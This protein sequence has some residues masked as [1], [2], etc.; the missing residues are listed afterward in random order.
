MK[1]KKQNFQK[2][3]RAAYLAFCKRRGLTVPGRFGHNE[4]KKVTKK[5]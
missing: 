2:E 1:A 4:V 5:K 3:V